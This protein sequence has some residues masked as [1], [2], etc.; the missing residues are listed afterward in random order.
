MQEQPR[1]VWLQLLLRPY[2]NTATLALGQLA[3]SLHELE[4]MHTVLRAQF[5][6]VRQHALRQLTADHFQQNRALLPL[7]LLSGYDD[8]YQLA[9][10][11]LYTAQAD[12]PALAAALLDGLLAADEN[13][14]A[15]L[16]PR[17]Q[18]LLTQPLHAQVA[19]AQLQALLA[20]PEAGVQHLGAILLADSDYA[21]EELGDCFAL[22][23][24]S[25]FEEV[26]AGAVALLA[27][28]DDAG[29]RRYLDLLCNAL[30]DTAAYPQQTALQV[31]R[32]VADPGL[33]QAVFAHILPVLFR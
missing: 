5:P 12:Y 2:E 32:E 33:Q 17:L 30:T 15:V 3:G 1:T 24:A 29:K 21:F 11:Y 25:A 7:L 23:A 27:K 10:D 28:L 4:V 16:L 14:R 19:L 22:M 13:L 6:S 9:K 20:H 8:V 26:R 18:W 31:L